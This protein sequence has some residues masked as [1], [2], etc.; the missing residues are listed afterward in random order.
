[1]KDRHGTRRY[2]WLGG[3]AQPEDVLTDLGRVHAIVAAV[4]RRDELAEYGPLSRET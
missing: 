4:E 1:V 2:D 3:A